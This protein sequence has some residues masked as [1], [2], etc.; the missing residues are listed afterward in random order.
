MYAQPSK[1]KFFQSEIEYL[2][3]LIGA[4]GIRVNP[5][6]VDAIPERQVPQD[7]GS[8]A[9]AATFQRLMN[10]IFRP[11]I[12]VLVLVYL[13]DI[14][15]FSKSVDEHREHLYKVLRLLREHQL[16]A[17]PSKCKFFQS[18][19]EYLGHLIGAYGIRVDPKR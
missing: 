3:H 10:D 14:Q 15:V 16:Y 11:F 7:A 19:I 9:P 1:C 6:K 2:G 5:K 4:N 12:D 17:Q 18:E 8:C 13:D